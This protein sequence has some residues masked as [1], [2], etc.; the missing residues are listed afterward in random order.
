M[1]FIEVL[2]DPSI[3]RD[4]LERGMQKNR[5]V[6]DAQCGHSE[7]CK[8]N[9]HLTSFWEKAVLLYNDPQKSY[10][11]RIYLTY[12]KPFD[13]SVTI[14]PVGE[15]YHMQAESLRKKYTD[16]R[17]TVDKIH[18]NLTK[19]GE[20]EGSNFSGD[21]VRSYTNTE[22]DAYMYLVLQEEGQ[23]SDFAQS[24]DRK[25]S[26]S[27]SCT[28]KTASKGASAKKQKRSDTPISNMSGAV[29][30][31][32]HLTASIANFGDT[33]R[34]NDRLRDLQELLRSDEN[35]LM[36][37]QT[38]MINASDQ[39][40]SILDDVE[41]GKTTEESIRFVARK[42]AYDACKN[43]IKVLQL[44]IERTNRDI[45]TLNMEVVEN[46]FVTPKKN[47]VE[48]EDDNE[49]EEFNLENDPFDEDDLS[50]HE[51]VDIDRIL[52]D[53]EIDDAEVFDDDAEVVDD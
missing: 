28:P 1:R 34:A 39:F 8:T 52:G 36:L 33:S 11:S 5:A 25:H 15:D 40:A 20:G 4:W 38:E 42:N 13:K 27:T 32:E 12:G 31:L 46:D 21:Q 51:G 44:R 24:F 48:E 45:E 16:S 7:Q 35:S 17:G 43:Q 9:D 49:C 18:V 19:S 37:R 2:M 23:V 10:K 14:H 47:S 29:D 41:Q 26:A 53:D 6:L 50:G 22:Q 30:A 3:K